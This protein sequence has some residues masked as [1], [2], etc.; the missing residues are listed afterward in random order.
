MIPTISLR[1]RPR[2]T[3][4]LAAWL[5]DGTE[6]TL[7]PDPVVVLAGSTI[8]SVG[9]GVPAP[10]E[11][12]VVD[13]GSA[14]LLPGLVDTHV[15]LA[16]DASR[17]PVTALAERDDAAVVQAMRE[18][19][20]TALTGGVT[21]VRDLG[22]RNYL[23]LSLRGDPAMPTI[24]AAG[25]PLTTP[26][27]HCHF[28]GGEV[29][30]GA[31][32]VRAAVR[33]HAAR[34]VDVIKIMASGGQLTAGSSQHLPQFSVEELRAAVDEAHRLGL[35][36][37]AHAHATQGIRNAV[38]AGVDGLEHA[39]FWSEDS[40]DDPGDMLQAIAARQIVVGATVGQVPVPGATP[41]PA[42]LKRMPLV[43]ANMLRMQQSG[44]RLV[45][46]TDAGI[47]PVKPH[48]V[49]RSAVSQ[50]VDLGMPAAAVL[51]TVTS[52]AAEVCGL[53][54]SKGRIATGY[55]ADLLAVD[56]DPIR[57]HDALHRIRAVYRAGQ[58]VNRTA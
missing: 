41:P 4:L 37:T 33:E 29:D 18:A 16:F 40:V 35:P 11:A 3:A 49:L 6:R 45:A 58:P 43:I 55:D 25:P 23:S 56:G 24:V 27:G 1:D 22:D 48:D 14:T 54:A 46:G 44:V 15:H 13:L 17:D 10:P 36:I 26:N 5:F 50:L 52:V 12:E 57:D 28:L 42:I 30:P 21:T 34:G 39:S 9:F 19:G 38:E 2:P 51:V 53:G 7:R 47:G 8:V 20:R 32:S 31:D